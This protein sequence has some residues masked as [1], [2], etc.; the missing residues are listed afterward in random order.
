[1]VVIGTSGGDVH[2]LEVSE[3]LAT[4]TVND[5][6][7][8]AVVLDRETRRE[9]LLENKQREMKLKEKEKEREQIRMKLG[10]PDPEEVEMNLAND[11]ARQAEIT[12]HLQ[13]DQLKLH[14]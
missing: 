11:L 8:M 6:P 7:A 12:F 14:C 4:S 13:I 1:M 9:K 10:L 5:R 2:L 3:N